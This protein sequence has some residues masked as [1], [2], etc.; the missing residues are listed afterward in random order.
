MKN[1]KINR[2]WLQS[3]FGV[4]PSPG[5]AMTATEVGWKLLATLSLAGVAVAED[6]HTP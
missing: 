6:G 2:A 5:A 4:R 1:V 3:A